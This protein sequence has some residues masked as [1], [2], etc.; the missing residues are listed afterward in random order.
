MHE[1]LAIKVA[2]RGSK[3][4]FVLFKSVKRERGGEEER[5]G[6]SVERPG[7]ATHTGWMEE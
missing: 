4:K 3:I 5:S 6:V 1:F 2:V 7:I